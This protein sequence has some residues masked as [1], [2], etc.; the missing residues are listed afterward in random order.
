MRWTYD[1]DVRETGSDTTAVPA[2]RI[3]RSSLLR[4][5]RDSAD[6]PLV[7]VSAGAGFGKTTLAAQWAEQDTRPHALVRVGRFMDDPATLALH[8]VDAL[9]SLGA[10]AGGT[11]AVITASE[12]RFSAV[13]LPALGRLAASPPTP[14]VLVVDDIHLLVDPDCHE[15]LHAVARGIPRGSQLAVMSR[16]KLPEAVAGPARRDASSTSGRRTWRST[17]PRASGCSRPSASR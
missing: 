1:H 15:V 9:E 6:V 14:Y 13:A 10:D 2:A 4:R 5:L 16:E 17:T 3:R 12:P 11:R 8:L 7:V